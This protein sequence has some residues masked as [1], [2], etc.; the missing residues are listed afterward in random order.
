MFSSVFKLALSILLIVTFSLL[1]SCDANQVNKGFVA[2]DITGAD[3]S[4]SFSLTDHTGKTRTMADFKGKVVLL[5]FGFTHC[6]DVCPTT[7]LD[8]KNAM[9]LLGDKADKVQVLFITV[10]PER[11]T[12]AVLAKFVPSFDSR[13]IGLRGDMEQTAETVKNFK[14]YYAKVPGKSENDYSIDHSAGMYAFDK[15][16]KARL[17]LGYGQNAKDIASDVQK[18]L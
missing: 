9:N 11:D 10:D 17:Y 14:I 15:Q 18:L 8:L 16:G 2:T 6:P 12:Q 4:K 5:F 13:F 1:A 3:F 7:M